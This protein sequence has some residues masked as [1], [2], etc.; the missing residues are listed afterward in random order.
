MRYLLTSKETESTFTGAIAIC[1]VA[2]IFLG[3]LLDGGLISAPAI[4]FY[5]PMAGYLFLRLIV[6]KVIRQ[7][8]AL[9]RTQRYAVALLP[10]YGFVVFFV[11]SSWIRSIR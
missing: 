7:V 11:I 8:P 3:M 9:T 6:W 4:W 1:L 5:F 10:L 2:G